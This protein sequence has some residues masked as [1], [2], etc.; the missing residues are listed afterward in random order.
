M[1]EFI[2]IEDSARVLAEISEEIR[3]KPTIDPELLSKFTNTIEQ[4]P[5]GQVDVAN[6]FRELKITPDGKITYNNIEI[7][8]TQF[9][10]FLKS[11]FRGNTVDFLKKELN[12]KD[13]AVLERAKVYD[14]FVGREYA[15]IKR[16][17][18]EKALTNGYDT[19]KEKPSWIDFNKGIDNIKNYFTKDTPPSKVQADLEKLKNDP[20]TPPEVKDSISQAEKYMNDLKNGNKDAITTGSGNII[21]RALVLGLTGLTLY[22]FVE[23]YRQHA[24]GCWIMDLIS[25]KKYKL[26]KFTN[27]IINES[28]IPSTS[29]T[30]TIKICPKCNDSC[31]IPDKTPC[32]D[33]KVNPTDTEFISYTNYKAPDN[34]GECSC[35]CSGCKDLISI[36]P[37]YQLQ[38]I[39]MSWTSALFDITQDVPKAASNFFDKFSHI[40]KIIS[41]VFI[42]LIVLMIIIKIAMLIF[43]K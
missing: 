31:E 3:L 15:G 7:K 30:D 43:K 9:D 33:K 17:D 28:D 6:N 1:G 35:Y 12:V 16:T 22:E 21:T 18:Y 23:A 13:P 11:Q 25:G 38:C 5:I 32:V 20:N 19:V 2:A 4:I 29:I 41:I 10:D 26:S 42:S 40:F 8:P 24:N 39:D 37:N 27:T 34:L 14:D 36:S